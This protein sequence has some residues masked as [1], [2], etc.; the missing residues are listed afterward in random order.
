MLGLP[1]HHTSR[2][3]KR[4]LFPTAVR[5]SSVIGLPCHPVSKSMSC[6]RG[7]DLPSLTRSRIN[8]RDGRTAACPTKI[9]SRRRSPEST[10][11]NPAMEYGSI[12][13]TWRQSESLVIRMTIQELH[14]ESTVASTSL[15]RCETSNKPIEGI[16]GLWT[17][18]E[19]ERRSNVQAWI[20]K[21]DSSLH[22]PATA[23]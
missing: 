6:E 19:S 3:C 1:L 12:S 18:S 9:T 22:Y 11:V 4:H 2:L 7:S 13:W 15:G 5:C 14:G 21:T 23:R 16:H 10:L 20:G 8:M 17:Y